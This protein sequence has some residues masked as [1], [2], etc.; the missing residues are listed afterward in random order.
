MTNA[1]GFHLNEESSKSWNQR[2]TDD[3]Q[4]RERRKIGIVFNSMGVWFESDLE[5]R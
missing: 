1:V 5:S 3:W 2:C 4:G